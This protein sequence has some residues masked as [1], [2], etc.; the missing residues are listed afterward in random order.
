VA[1]AESLLDRSQASAMMRGMDA[2]AANAASADL[3]AGPELD[4]AVAKKCGWEP[5]VREAPFN[6]GVHCTLMDDEI[7]DALIP[8]GFFE[9]S[10]N[11]IAAF[12]AAE[13]CGLFDCCSLGRHTIGDRAWCVFT[14]DAEG[15]TVAEASTPALAISR[16][17]L[18]LESA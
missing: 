8:L 9:P 13:K 12:E 14:D 3:E 5:S 17:I 18:K 10:T 15:D 6:K 1:A 7:P 16:A 11:L 2:K 4:A